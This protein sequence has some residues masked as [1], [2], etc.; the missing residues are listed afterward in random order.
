MTNRNI[1]LVG[2]VGSVLVIVAGLVG[3]S[4]FVVVWG[5]VLLLA[6]LM[7]AWRLP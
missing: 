4:I 1:S 6:H 5:L 2:I 7:L 3:G